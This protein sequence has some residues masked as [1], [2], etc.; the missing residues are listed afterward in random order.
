MQ[1]SMNT[2]LTQGFPGGLYGFNHD[3]IGRNNY[4][5]KLDQVTITAA[6]LATTCTING[7]A[8]TV[9]VG[10]AVL[11]KT[12]LAELLA[13]AIN[14]GAEP[15]TAYF[16]AAA[17]LITVESDVVGTT[18]TVVGTTNCSVVAQI[19]NAAAVGFGL[20]V[21]QDLLYTEVARVPIVATDIT[22]AKLARGITVQTQAIEQNYQS[23]GGDGYAL[24]AEMSIVKRGAV[25]V[26]AETAM[27]VT[28]DVYARYTVSGTTVLGGIR[29]D[30]DT[31]KAAIIPTARVVRPVTA[32]GLC[33]IELNL[34]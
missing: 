25:W 17:E 11:T 9:N 31:A 20:F 3:I 34:P 29:N 5:K 2:S 24:N 33:L 1:S 21:C 30:A 23:A 10:A 7:T 13:A 26:T 12:A 8:F 15:V 14:A 27:A 19:G 32:A 16:T 6:D 4:S 22:N 18:T 28:D